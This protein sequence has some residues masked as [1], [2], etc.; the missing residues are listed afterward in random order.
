MKKESKYL[1][2]IIENEKKEFENWKLSNFLF[3]TNKEVLTNFVNVENNFEKNFIEFFLFNKLILNDKYDLDKYGIKIK[4]RGNSLMENIKEVFKVIY[5]EKYEDVFSL[6]K[7]IDEFSKTTKEDNWNI[8]TE[9]EFVKKH[10]ALQNHFYE[11]GM[12][13]YNNYFLL[14][15]KI[16]F[17]KQKGIREYEQ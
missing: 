11:N 5:K 16:F 3:I 2:Q 6:L 17:E 9:Y 1:K 14:L 15:N 7:L 8:N 12:K 13:S 10:W 4:T